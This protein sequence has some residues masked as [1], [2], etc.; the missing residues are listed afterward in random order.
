MF[1]KQTALLNVRD[2]YIT[3]AVVVDV[4]HVCKTLEPYSWFVKSRPCQ[5][6]KPSLISFFDTS[7]KFSAKYKILLY[8]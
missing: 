1:A 2:I 3:K 8:S 7:P 5:L 6:P 4:L